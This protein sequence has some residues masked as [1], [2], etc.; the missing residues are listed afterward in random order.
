MIA[1]LTN[2]PTVNSSYTYKSV[3]AVVTLVSSS[4]ASWTVSNWP[5]HHINRSYQQIISTRCINR[6]YQLNMLH[7][8]AM[9]TRHINTW[10]QQMYIS[11][12]NIDINF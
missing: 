10:C 6:S 8:Y 4:M 12:I 5:L 2:T 3:S 1:N 11:T 9:A 7:H